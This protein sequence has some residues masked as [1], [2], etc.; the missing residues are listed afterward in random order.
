MT[1]NLLELVIIIG[2]CN[3]TCVS[4]IHLG[5]LPICVS[6]IRDSGNFK[7]AKVS[8]YQYRAATIA[9]V[10]TLV[11]FV[12]TGTNMQRVVLQE[13]AQRTVINCSS[14]SEWD[15]AEHLYAV[16]AKSAG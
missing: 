8:T 12:V 5:F 15:Q 3:K 6:I 9:L 4:S 14:R 11:V 10:L 16:W 13:N 7:T 1:A 2:V